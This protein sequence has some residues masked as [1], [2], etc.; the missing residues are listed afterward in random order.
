MLGSELRCGCHL[1]PCA[2]CHGTGITQLPLPEGGFTDGTGCAACCGA[3]RVFDECTQHARESRA[4]GV[5][6]R[7]RVGAERELEAAL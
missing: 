1:A 3:G 5:P 6:R 4:L 7:R 2:P